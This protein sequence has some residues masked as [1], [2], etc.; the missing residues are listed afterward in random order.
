MD[1]INNAMANLGYDVRGECEIPDRH[2]FSKNV[3]GIRTHKAHLCVRNH[4]LVLELIVF[5]D[6][7][8]DHPD[9]AKTY[10]SLKVNLANSNT[11]GIRE[12]LDGKE[13]YIRDVIKKAVNEG[14]RM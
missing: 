14:Y 5:R 7:L 12:Y 9:E 3:D 4:P 11:S 13:G 10:E 1:P 6:Y 2:Y 8:R